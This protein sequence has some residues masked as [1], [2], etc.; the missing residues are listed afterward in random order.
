MIQYDHIKVYHPTDIGRW[1][2]ADCVIDVRGYDDRTNSADCYLLSYEII[3]QEL[4]EDHDWSDVSWVTDKLVCQEGQ[5][6]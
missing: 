6:K 2:L 3:D 4:T 1:A 5:L